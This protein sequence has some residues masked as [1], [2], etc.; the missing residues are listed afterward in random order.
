M[1]HFQG[2]TKFI[3]AKMDATTT[4]L[5]HLFFSGFS[6]GGSAFTIGAAVFDDVLLQA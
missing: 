1:C 4:G 5:S 2:V 3:K 6:A